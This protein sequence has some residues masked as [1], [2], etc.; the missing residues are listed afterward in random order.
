[1]NP[2][3]ELMVLVNANPFW[4]MFGAYALGILLSVISGIKLT[5]C[6]SRKQ[7]R[8]FEKS[9]FFALSSWLLWGTHS[10]IS[11]SSNHQ[12]GFSIAYEL[13]LLFL[14]VSFGLFLAGKYRPRKRS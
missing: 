14:A 13:F 5:Y 10:L 2:I 6:M 1:M 7:R 4:P 9:L 11:L 12:E 3:T 8:F